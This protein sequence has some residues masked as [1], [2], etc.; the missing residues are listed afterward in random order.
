MDVTREAPKSSV[1]PSN[2]PLR[3]VLPNGDTVQST[4]TCTLA[5][6]QLPA[7]ARCGHIIPGLAAYSLLSVV[8][9]CDA[10]CDVTF[11]K[12]DCMVCMCGRVLPLMASK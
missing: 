3:V 8:K 6:P 2:N 9:L 5:L 4:H 7:K 12:I 11:T 10:G 1:S